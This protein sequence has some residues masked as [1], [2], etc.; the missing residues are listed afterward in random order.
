MHFHNID[1]SSTGL[2]RISVISFC[3]K[4][5]GMLKNVERLTVVF[6]SGRTSGIRRASREAIHTADRGAEGSV[7]E[8]EGSSLYTGE[9]TGPAKV[10]D[11]EFQFIS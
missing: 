5:A 10:S 3:L 6:V 7:G 9:R 11:A 4:S 8:R 1:Q 2:E